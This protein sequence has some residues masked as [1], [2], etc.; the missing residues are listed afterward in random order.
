MVIVINRAVARNFSWGRGG[1]KMGPK[2]V[3]AEGVALPRNVI[4]PLMAG[5]GVEPITPSPVYAPDNQ[6]RSRWPNFGVFK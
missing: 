4:F 6:G 3:V 1:V 5:G 2:Q